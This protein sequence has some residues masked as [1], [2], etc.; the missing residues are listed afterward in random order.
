M[1]KVEVLFRN[2][3]PA[4]MVLFAER[5]AGAREARFQLEVLAAIDLEAEPPA[6]RV[7]VERCREALLRKTGGLSERIAAL[8]QSPSLPTPT[9]WSPL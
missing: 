5:A 2:R 3:H 9:P 6:E 8:E 4:A 1:S 7:R